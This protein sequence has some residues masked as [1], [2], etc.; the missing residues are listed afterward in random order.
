MYQGRKKDSKDSFYEELEQVFDHFL[1]FHMKILLGDF[2]T[3]VGTKNI[4]TPT[5]G[6]ESL[7]QDNNNNGVKTVKFVTSNTLLVKRRMCRAEIFISTTG[8]LL[9]G[10]L[11]ARLITY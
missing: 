11:T 9:T 8:P 1:K 5:I 3:K 7:Q 10:R 6:N 4:F 2:N